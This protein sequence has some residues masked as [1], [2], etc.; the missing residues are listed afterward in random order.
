ME[1]SLLAMTVPLAS[2]TPMGRVVAS[3]IWISTL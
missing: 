2:M 1:S 3:F